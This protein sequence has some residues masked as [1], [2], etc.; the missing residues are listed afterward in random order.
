M[1]R[2]CCPLLSLEIS[3]SA[4]PANWILKL[5]GPEGVKAFLRAEFPVL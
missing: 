3:G 2:L 4:D 1:E 5:T